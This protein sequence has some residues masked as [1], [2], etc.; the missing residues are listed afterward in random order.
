VIAPFP[1][2][3]GVNYRDE[4]LDDLV[5]WDAAYQEDSR[6]VPACGEMIRKVTRHGPV[7]IGDQNAM[8]FF[9]P[10]QEVWIFR[11]QRWSVDVADAHDIDGGC[12]LR[13]MA[14]YLAQNE[15]AQVLVNDEANGHVSRS[16]GLLRVSLNAF[17]T[18]AQ[19]GEAGCRL[20]Q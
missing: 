11:A 13:I 2:L 12:A 17:H 10:D 1:G 18:L 6:T 16:L 4:E 15:A 19:L 5:L 3:A 20:R 14:D 9:R 8:L 7:I